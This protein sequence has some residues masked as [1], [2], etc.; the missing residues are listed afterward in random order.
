MKIAVYR[1]EFLEIALAI[2]AD[3]NVSLMVSNGILSIVIL[4]IIGYMIESGKAYLSAVQW[5]E[6]VYSV[7]QSEKL[8]VDITKPEK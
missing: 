4:K 8:V 1:A 3:S 2:P 7:Y 5:H 6:L